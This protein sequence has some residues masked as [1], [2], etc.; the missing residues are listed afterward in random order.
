MA[1]R[2]A[3]IIET[4]RPFDIDELLSKKRQIVPPPFGDAEGNG[5]L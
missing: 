5:T 2:F 3:L 4:A 1:G